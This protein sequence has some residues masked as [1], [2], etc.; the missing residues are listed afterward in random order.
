MIHESQTQKTM[1]LAS[2]HIAHFSPGY[3]CIVVGI[4][5]NPKRY[6]TWDVGTS[7]TMNSEDVVFRFRKNVTF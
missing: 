2:R 1:Y 6:V 5:N 7:K 4:G 3:I